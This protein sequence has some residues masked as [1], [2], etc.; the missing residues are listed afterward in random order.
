MIDEPEDPNRPDNLWK[1]LP[2]DHGAHGV[3][4]DRAT[5]RSIEFELNKQRGWILAGA[6]ALFLAY[7]LASRR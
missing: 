4:D 7:S 2:G 5:D 6:A 1:P 3:F